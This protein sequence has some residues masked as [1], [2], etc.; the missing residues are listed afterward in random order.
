M[1]NKSMCAVFDCDTEGTCF[2][3]HR[4]LQICLDVAFE[5]FL[6]FLS[7]G[8]RRLN[9]TGFNLHAVQQPQIFATYSLADITKT[10][11]K[12]VSINLHLMLFQ[13]P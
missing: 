13:I 11:A 3:S 4:R 7:S 2:N 1:A 10:T 12:E 9:V 6:I 5:I 8:G